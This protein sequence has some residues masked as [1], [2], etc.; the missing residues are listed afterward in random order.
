M[1]S[2][3]QDGVHEP[4]GHEGLGGSDVAKVDDRVG[5]APSS[6]SNTRS[7]TEQ[8]PYR[9]GKPLRQPFAGQHSARRG[10]YRVRYRVDDGKHLVTV[11]DIAYRADAYHPGRP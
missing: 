6:R 4:W 3:A 7:T 5:R 9:V 8:R 1:V 11:I 10:A 2:S